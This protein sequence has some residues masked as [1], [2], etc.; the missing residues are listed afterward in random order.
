MTV[1]FLSHVAARLCDRF[2]PRIRALT[3]LPQV[4]AF[5]EKHF[6]VEKTSLKNSAAVT[7]R[8]ISGAEKTAEIAGMLGGKQKS[9]AQALKHA[10]EL[11]EESN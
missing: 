11:L 9:S 2:R 1:P 10:A 4:A 7:A 5:A 3:H 6:I 8:A